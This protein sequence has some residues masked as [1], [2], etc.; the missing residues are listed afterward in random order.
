[1]AFL[2]QRGIATRRGIPPIHLQAAYAGENQKLPI[3]E[4]VANSS[5]FL[6]LFTQMTEA[7]V[8]HVIASVFDGIRSQSLTLK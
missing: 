6:P 4:A 3:T 2:Q 5:L 7:E 8:E 1:M